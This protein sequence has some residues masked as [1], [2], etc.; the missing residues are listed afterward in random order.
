MAV[1]TTP[2]TLERAFELARS[3]TCSSLQ[4]IRRRLKGE[5]FDQVEAHLAGPA[6]GKQL[7]RLCEE[8]RP[9]IA[10]GPAAAE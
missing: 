8:A 9:V 7:R 6:I 4:D 3:G 2:T 5:G 10:E 1:M